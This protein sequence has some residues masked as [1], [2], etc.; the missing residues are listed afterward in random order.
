M[1]DGRRSGSG[2]TVMFE[3][4]KRRGI[5]QLTI[6]HGARAYHFSAF[7][8]D[9]FR[10]STDS[11][12]NSTRFIS[13]ASSVSTSSSSSSSSQA[14]VSC[15]SAR[16]E[17]DHGQ[18]LAEPNGGW[19]RFLHHPS[20]WLEIHGGWKGRGRTRGSAGLGGEQVGELGPAAGGLGHALDAAVKGLPRLE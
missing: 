5:D 17:G 15:A 14:Q 16:A 10:S 9:S 13:D 12:I 6:F 1:A 20:V 7:G 18:S 19:R 11:S 3:V 8:I 2:R 4:G